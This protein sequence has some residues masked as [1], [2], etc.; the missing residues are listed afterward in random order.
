MGGFEA[1]VRRVR[2][3]AQRLRPSE[4]PAAAPVKAQGRGT[5]P[6]PLTEDESSLLDLL[7]P[8]YAV[9]PVRAWS[10]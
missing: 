9:G 1:A 8:G 3:A 10:C 4:P 2:R 5:E 7:A 6:A